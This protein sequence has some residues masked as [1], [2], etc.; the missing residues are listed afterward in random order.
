M[1]EKHIDVLLLFMPCI[2]GRIFFIFFICV[3]TVKLWMFYIYFTLYKGIT[4]DPPCMWGS[5]AF[6][7]IP[8]KYMV[9]AVLYG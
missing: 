7:P 8:I 2:E 1:S 4:I 3:D 9:R 5:I 6:N